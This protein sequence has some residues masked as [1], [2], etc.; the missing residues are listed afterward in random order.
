M[1]GVAVIHIHSCEFAS[2]ETVQ[3]PPERLMW[4]KPDFWFCDFAAGNDHS[5]SCR[6]VACQEEKRECSHSGWADSHSGK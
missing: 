3:A 1:A 4:T 2:K 6:L 5:S